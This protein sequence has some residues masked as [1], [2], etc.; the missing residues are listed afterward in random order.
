MIRI[1]YL[2]LDGYT[3][4]PGRPT[5]FNTTWSSDVCVMY[6]TGHVITF[7]GVAY[8]FPGTCQYEMVASTRTA[9]FKVLFSSDFRQG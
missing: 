3:L 8:D 7:D 1:Y 4:I 2:F 5:D 6:G 9:D